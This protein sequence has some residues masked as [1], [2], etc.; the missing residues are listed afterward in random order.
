MLNFIS[1]LPEK[2]WETTFPRQVCLLGSTGSIGTNALRVLDSHP[3]LFS[4]IALAA[5]RNVSLLAKQA[6]QWHPAWLAVQDEDSAQKLTDLLAPCKK[7]YQPKILFGQE[8]YAR[9]A[10]L[11]EV[12]TVLSAQ[13]GAAA[14][15]PTLAAAQAGKVICLANKESLVLAGQLLRQTCQKTGAVILPVDS[16]HNTIFQLLRNRNPEQVQK[17]IL[18]ASGGPFRG[19]TH[20]ELQKVTKEQALKHPSWSMGAKITIDSATMMNKGL[21]MIEAWHLFGMPSE[22]I[23]VLVH[24]Q[25]IIHSLVEFTDGS[26][27]ALLATPDMRLP[28]SYCLSWPLLPDV[29]VAPLKLSA[30]KTLTFE[31]PDP[32]SFPCLDLARE[33]LTKQSRDHLS[34]VA[35][36]LNAANEVAVNA[37]LQ[38][39]IG[40]MDI[41]ALIADALDHCD[42]PDPDS[43]EDIEKIDQKTRQKMTLI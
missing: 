38:D 42:F 26:Q 19:K 21:E 31:E 23:A 30:I 13:M 14:L 40:F 29:K 43:L 8:G 16:E 28:L 39:R 36:V 22:K 24:P 6:E 3:E 17:L 25:S 34:A 11:P 37:F 4:V 10:S 41:P 20:K 18:T 35:V 2:A 9:V 15:R 12:S 5:G 1:P 27:T 7:E 33:V 32:K